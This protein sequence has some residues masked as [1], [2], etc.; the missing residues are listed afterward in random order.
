MNIIKLKR[1]IAIYIDFVATIIIATIIMQIVTLGNLNLEKITNP[2]FIVVV[3]ALYFILIIFIITRKDLIF[4]NASIGKKIMNI[5][6]YMED[7]KIPNRY[8]IIKRIS[9]NLIFFPL[10][11]LYILIRGQSSGDLEY[12]TVIKSKKQL[13]RRI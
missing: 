7:G 12:K 13:T 8:I 2:I 5:E 4:K 6:I 9:S 3:M 11:I 10:E 1:L